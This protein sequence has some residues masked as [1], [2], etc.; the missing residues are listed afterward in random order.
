[1]SAQINLL[2]T[3]EFAESAIGKLLKFSLTYGR[4]I[5]V[6]TQLVVLLSF[7]SRFSID[8]ELVDLQESVE[9]K[10]AI[11]NSLNGFETEVRLLQ[12]KIAQIKTLK[13]NHDYIRKSVQNIKKTLPEGNRLTQL[14][15]TKEMIKI[16]GTSENEESLISFI[17]NLN[18]NNLFSSAQIS[19]I[20]KKADSGQIDFEAILVL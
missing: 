20:N 6:L 9:Q 16:N 18:S 11:I 4:Y 7:F 17:D 3:K 1:M 5:I 19:Q 8:R 10:Q 13:E 14:A 15:I 2:P 12:G